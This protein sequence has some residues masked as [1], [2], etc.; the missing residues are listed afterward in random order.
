MA[1]ELRNAVAAAL[2]RTLPATLLFKHPTLEALGEFVMNLIA[3]DAPAA[4]TAEAPA[5][6]G[7]AALAPLT[8]EETRQLLSEELQSLAAWTTG[9]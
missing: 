6:D 1:V 3:A 7:A 8:D 4:K 9:E 5:A 2:E